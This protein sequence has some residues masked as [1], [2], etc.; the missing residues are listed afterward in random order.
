MLVLILGYTELALEEMDP[1]LP[2]HDDLEE[3]RKAANR[4]ADF[5]RQ[6]LAF[7]RKQTVAPKVLDL[8]ETV[9]STLK[10]LRRLIGENINLVWMPGKSMWPVKVDPSQIDQILANLCV[11]ARDAIADVGRIAIKTGSVLFDADYCAAREGVTPGEYVVLAVSDN[12]CGMNKETLDKLFEP[13]FTTKAVGQGTGLGLATV[14]GAVKQNGGFINVSSEPGKGTTFEIYLPRH[15]GNVGQAQGTMPEALVVHGKQTILLVE[16]EP[17]I[18][19]MT[20]RM[21]ERQ[22]YKVLAAGSP[23]D[24]IRVAGENA[25]KV[26]L[27]LTDVVMP[28]MN[29]RDLARKLL[30]Q[31]PGL[32]CLFMSGYTADV[33]AHH[34]VLDEGVQF[35]RKP[36]STRDLSVKVRE[37]LDG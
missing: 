20:T 17:A 11:N 8:N 31:H 27:L 22:G 15:A 35:I 25:G 28:E 12:G 5:T 23:G 36:F 9:E 10:M 3:I 34:G 13:F 24:G 19:K 26:H 2:L 6:F 29:G 7:A 16:D 4:S 37:A 32:K 33:I 1:S 21:L 30:S 14:Y 18:L